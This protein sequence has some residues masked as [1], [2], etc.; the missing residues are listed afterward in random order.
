MGSNQAQ[1]ITCDVFR[2]VVFVISYATNQIVEVFVKQPLEVS[3]HFHQS[4]FAVFTSKCTN[5]AK[6]EKNYVKSIFENVTQSVNFVLHCFNFRFYM[7]KLVSKFEVTLGQ[8]Q[9]QDNSKFGLSNL[10]KIGILTTSS[11]RNCQ[12]WQFLKL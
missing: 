3:L 1:K 2:F 7:Q 8:N 12:K 5:T 9:K 11:L 4:H 10:D 6:W